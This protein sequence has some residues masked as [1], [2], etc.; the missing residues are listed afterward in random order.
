MYYLETKTLKKIIIETQD[1]YDVNNTDFELKQ[2]KVEFKNLCKLIWEIGR[3]YKN[4]R[5]IKKRHISNIFKLHL[6]AKDKDNKTLAEIVFADDR[7]SAKFIYYD[8]IFEALMSS[9]LKAKGDY[10]RWET[11]APDEL[12]K[13][14][15]RSKS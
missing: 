1:E 2:S 7:S 8:T 4:C 10:W 5:V 13:Q 14:I 15:Q 11:Y 12:V 6:Y 9:C 3:T